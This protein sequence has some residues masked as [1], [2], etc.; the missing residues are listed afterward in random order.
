LALGIAALLSFP[1]AILLPIFTKINRK[2]TKLVLDNTCRYLSIFTI[3]AIF[4]LLVLGKYFIRLIYGYEYLPS[5]LPFY[6]LVFLIFPVVFIGLLISLFSAEERPEIFTK[7]VLVSSVINI[8]LNFIF[9][10]LFLSISE[11]WAL[12]GAA[13]AT[14]ISWTIYLIASV[15]YVRKEFN[16]DIPLRTIIKPLIASL[17]MAGVLLFSLT[18]IKDMSLILGLGEIALGIF[19]YLAIMILIG[20]INKKDLLLIKEIF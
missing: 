15:Y 6:V 9:I 8:I 2:N 7:L 11:L 18:F 16:F 12:V 10:K 3:P 1:N 5:T 13:I 19:V 14:L 17:I 4:G 20:G